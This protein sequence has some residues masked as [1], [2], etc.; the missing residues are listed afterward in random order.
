V[1][2]SLGAADSRKPAEVLDHVLE[3]L[4]AVVGGD[5]AVYLRLGPE[6]AVMSVKDRGSF[7]FGDAIGPRW[8]GMSPE[9]RAQAVLGW[10]GQAAR[11]CRKPR[12][13]WAPA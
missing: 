9:E 5:Q 13:R 11:Y 12:V 3:D 4:A 10:I 7:A 1:R 2:S 6:G 8:H